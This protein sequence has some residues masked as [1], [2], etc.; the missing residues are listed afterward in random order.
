MTI[1]KV[2]L[3]DDHPLMRRGINQ[4]LSFEGEFEVIAEA[5]TIESYPID[6]VVNIRF[7]PEKIWVLP[8][9]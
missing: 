1:C 5:N 8:P 7:P 3:V 4:L 9:E 2:M 6:S